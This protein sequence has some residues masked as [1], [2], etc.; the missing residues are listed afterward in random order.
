MGPS[1]RQV[2]ESMHCASVTPASASPTVMGGCACTTA[3]TSGR[4]W[5]AAW[6]I[7]YSD[8]GLCAPLSLR[9]STSTTIRSSSRMNPLW[10]PEGVTSTRSS[11]MRAETLPSPAAMN[12]CRYMRWQ[13]S[14]TCLR[15]SGSRIGS[16]MPSIYHAGR[17]MRSLPPLDPD[18]DPAE[19]IAALGPVLE[20]GRAAKLDAVAA[21]R[22][23]GVTLV[24]EDLIDPHNYGAVLRSAESMGLLHVHTINARNRF[25]VSPRVTQNCERWL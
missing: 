4:S 3:R 10:K 18:L 19:V 11:S 8:D 9:P 14:T 22:L 1:T 7:R 13:I 23:G 24:I 5:Y 15:R 21:A 2:S 12:P 20:E 16:R 17:P 6:C 25:R